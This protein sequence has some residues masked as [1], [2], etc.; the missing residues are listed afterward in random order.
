MC[1]PAW[2]SARRRLDTT[3]RPDSSASHPTA[4]D[5]SRKQ[6]TEPSACGTRTLDL[7]G[8]V[9][10]PA[11]HN[12]PAAYPTFTDG[13]NMVVIAADDGETY[14]WDTRVNQAIAYACT[15]AGRNLTHDEWAQTFGNRPYE[16]PAHE[17]DP[18]GP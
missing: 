10:T 18:L 1:N 14:R 16:K 17:P 13:S 5:W 4:H 15:M 7:L 6:P 12:T 11:A 8:T 2:S 3:T 9:T